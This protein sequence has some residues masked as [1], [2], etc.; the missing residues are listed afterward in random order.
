MG[1]VPELHWEWGGGRRFRGGASEVTAGVGGAPG[2]A[3]GV[4]RWAEPAQEVAALGSHW[5]CTAA[6]IRP[7]GPKEEPPV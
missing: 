1:G 6:R 3:L 4:G 7:I 2:S 5:F